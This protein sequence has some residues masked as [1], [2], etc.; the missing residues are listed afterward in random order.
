MS[1]TL[2][3]GD[4]F[5]WLAFLV[6]N[7]NLVP[8]LLGLFQEWQSATSIDAKAEVLKSLID[9][10]KGVIGELPTGTRLS[11][12]AGV[13]LLAGIGFTM[14][15]FIAELGFAA[16]PDELLMAKTGVLLA[17]LIAGFGGYIWLRLA[18]PAMPRSDA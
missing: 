9:L 12:I 16:H 18:A 17:S 11:Q 3:L 8:A 14:S 4:R 5:R 10:L 13:S 6:K 1:E 15:I 2:A 7:A